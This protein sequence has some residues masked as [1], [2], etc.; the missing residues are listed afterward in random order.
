MPKENNEKIIGD[1]LFKTEMHIL[2][3]ETVDVEALLSLRRVSEYKCKQTGNQSN[4]SVVFG[5]MLENAKRI[6]SA[7]QEQSIN[8]LKNMEEELKNCKDSIDVNEKNIK[9][10]KDEVSALKERQIKEIKGRYDVLKKETESRGSENIKNKE[11]EIKDKYKA[12]ETLKKQRE[13]ELATKPRKSNFGLFI[14]ILFAILLLCY[15]WIFYST[16]TYS[17][18]FK[19]EADIGV[20][21]A[22]HLFSIAAIMKAWSKGWSVGLFI[23]LFPLI[24]VILGYIT[25]SADDAIN[26]T[27]TVFKKFA[28]YCKK[29][30]LLTFVLTYNILIAYIITG[31]IYRQAGGLDTMES[32]NFGICLKDPHF[33]LIT[34]A[35]YIV[36]IVFGYICAMASKRWAE[37]P[38][39]E[40]NV[41]NI[42]RQIKEANA[43]IER[44]NKDIEA[45]KKVQFDTLVQLTYHYDE[46]LISARENPEVIEL[47]GKIEILKN[48]TE[49]LIEKKKYLEERITRIRY[50]N[51][52]MSAHEVGIYK[53]YLDGWISALTEM[54]SLDLVQKCHNT[55]TEFMK[56]NCGF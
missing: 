15:L 5:E 41:R 18:F 10:T 26:E 22:N 56:N 48:Y 54:Q 2:R 35:G 11:D 49:M 21:I 6:R 38:P 45:D 55:Y 31:D 47:E 28:K 19:D 14:E 46:D 7:R 17:A 29:F 37:F 16:A 44:L 1:E 9:D 34:G 20:N 33:W 30:A 25:F 13:I 36:Y 43:D 32:F 27:K 4:S 3:S 12:I 51:I 42:E 8:M 50:L 24:F 53:S 52:T 39:Q 23:T 40:N